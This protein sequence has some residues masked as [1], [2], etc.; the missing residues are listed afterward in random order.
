MDLDLD[1]VRRAAGGDRAALD[2][3]WR[4]HRGFVASVLLGHAPADAEVEDLLQD[5][6][7]AVVRGIAGL[8]EPRALRSW[9]R[10]V[11]INV[12]RSARRRARVRA[13][14][15]V[16]GDGQEQVGDPE[17]ARRSAVES[18]ATRLDGALAAASRLAPRYR[19]PLL[20]KALHG[21]SNEQVAAALG[22]G[23]RTVDTRLA[24]ARRML[25]ARLAQTDRNH[26]P[27]P[28]A[29]DAARV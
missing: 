17:P 22:V 23:P 29:R 3:L 28:E 10:Q 21:W 15:R 7:L 13:G 1:T 25:R 18:A 2:G 20:L 6:A 27:A 14:E 9:L 26:V 4:E 5:V 11:A 16:L 19:E 8:S 12:A 24:R